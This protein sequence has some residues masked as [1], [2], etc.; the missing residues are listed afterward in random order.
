[1]DGKD[2]DTSQT[3]TVLNRIV[4]ILDTYI[5]FPDDES[6]DAS[7]LWTMHT[8]VYHSFENTPRLSV[9]SSE[10]ASGKTR[11]LEVIREMC[12]NPMLAVSMTQSTVYR[13][14]KK[15]SM[16][17]LL[18]D[19]VDTIFGRSGSSSSHRDLQGILNSGYRRGAVVP[20]A[21]GTDD[22]ENFPTFAPVA[23]SGLGHLPDALGT[24]AVHIKMK[25]ASG[26]R[27]IKPLRMR[28][29]EPV[30]NRLRVELGK[31]ALEYAEALSMSLPSMPDGVVD[32]N[33]DIWEPLIA[34]ADL[35]GTDWSER[36]R[37]ACVHLIGVSSKKDE[38]YP[39]KLL[40]QIR[41]IYEEDQDSK[42]VFTME[43]I[44]KLGPS[45]GLNPKSLSRVMSE[46]DVP[47]S[48]LRISGSRARGYKWSD[49]EVAWKVL[50]IHPKIKED[51]D[52]FKV[53]SDGA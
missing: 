22:V 42:G 41:E 21:V 13:S 32:R 43:L 4:D 31:W 18:F 48:D 5:A 50:G 39:V 34:I 37:K 53:T 8:W 15:Y 26:T 12:P 7:A 33:A 10:P 51:P 36:S 9:S 11:V 38:P 25:R 29:A 40:S 3:E 1:M 28:F 16:L 27:S 20:R 14:I 52:E 17:T 2:I 23:M 35:A 6:R 46:Y 19:E 49:V 44:E 24:R 30:F 47:I 45:W